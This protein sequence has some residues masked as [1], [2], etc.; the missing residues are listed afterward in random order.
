VK[1]SVQTL[2]TKLKPKLDIAK[3]P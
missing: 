2:S 1:T 3:T